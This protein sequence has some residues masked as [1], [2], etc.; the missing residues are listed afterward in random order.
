MCGCDI[1]AKACR[2]AANL[3]TTTLV[4]RPIIA[5]SAPFFWSAT[6]WSYSSWGFVLLSHALAGATGTSFDAAMRERIFE[7]A[8]MEDT[9]LDDP[10]REIERRAAGYGLDPESGVTVTA[11]PVDNSCK[12]GAGGYLS[13][14]P[15]LVRFLSAFA[16]GT[17]ASPEM[18]ALVLR[19]EPEYRAIGWSEGGMAY[20]KVDVESGVAVAI[21]TNTLSEPL[22]ER[23]LAALE[24][25]E[26][27]ISRAVAR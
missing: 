25:A 10:E 24:K 15:D 19:G 6:H 16:S 22:G 9:V 17:I 21:A 3:R 14:A 1:R 23:L 18:Q 26:K 8:G 13:T 7:P 27:K 12:F 4:S 2:S 11:P 5:A 20:M